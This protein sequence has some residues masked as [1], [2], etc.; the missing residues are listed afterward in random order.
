MQKAP[1]FEIPHD[2]RGKW[3]LWNELNGKV[4]RGETLEE[5]AQCFFE[6]YPN[7]ASYRAFKQT[8]ELLGA[9]AH[10]G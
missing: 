9:N 4:Q 5:K 1:A 7:T 6:A 8:H 2:D 10:Q 3:Y